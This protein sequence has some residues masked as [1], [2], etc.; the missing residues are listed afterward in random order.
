MRRDAYDKDMVCV[1][2]CPPNCPVSVVRD[3]ASPQIARLEHRQRSV[4]VRQKSCM[5]F[6][7]LFFYYFFSDMFFHVTLRHCKTRV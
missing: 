4:N 2:V 7:F 6:H 1:N 5:T 3:R